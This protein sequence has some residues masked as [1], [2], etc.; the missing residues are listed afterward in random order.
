MCLPF[1][2][3]FRYYITIII[4][5]SSFSFQ[6]SSF[7]RVFIECMVETCTVLDFFISILPSV[8][9]TPGNK[10]LRLEDLTSWKHDFVFPFANTIHTCTLFLYLFP[11]PWISQKPASDINHFYDTFFILVIIKQASLN[12]PPLVIVHPSSSIMY[13]SSPILVVPC[14]STSYQIWFYFSH[15]V[16]FCIVFFPLTWP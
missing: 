9:N 13:S 1:F 2:F 7:R 15:F 12:F 14:Y 3:K 11:P 10:R 8:S 16:I 4:Y 6:V 5:S